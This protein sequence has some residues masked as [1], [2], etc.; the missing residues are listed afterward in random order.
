MATGGSN[1][2]YTTVKDNFYGIAKS[3]SLDIKDFST[4][5][6]EKN[7]INEHQFKD[8][9]NESSRGKELLLILLTKIELDA[10][11]FYTIREIAESMP[12]QVTLLR[13]LQT[14]VSI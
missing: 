3:I 1:I 6:F 12:T 4:K 7:L 2:E 11:A 14:D 5:C 9:L 13:L 8:A 10:T